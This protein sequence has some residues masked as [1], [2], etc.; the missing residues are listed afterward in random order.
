MS[1]CKQVMQTGTY[2]H[3]HQQYKYQR[4]QTRSHSKNNLVL[5]LGMYY[6][7]LFPD[8]N[9]FYSAEITFIFILAQV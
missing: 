2:T 8:P 9:Q 1:S 3:I 5:V 4:L 6:R 7:P